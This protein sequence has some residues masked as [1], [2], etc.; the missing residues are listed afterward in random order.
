MMK[1]MSLLLCAVLFAVPAV[2]QTLSQADRD[3]GV[4]YLKQ[5]RE[6][7]VTAVKGLSDAQLNFKPAPDRWSIAEVLEHIS[8]AEGFIL[9]NVE[10]KIMKAPAGDATRDVAKTDAF[11]VAAIPD[12]SHKFQAPEPLKPTGHVPASESLSKFIAARGQ[13]IEFLQSTP[14]LR[15]HVVDSPLGKPLDAYEWLLFIGGH[16]ERH[17][18][19]ILEVKADPN[20]PKQ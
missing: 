11:V 3:H 13:T 10:Q 20:F 5:T 19:Q 9:Q 15:Q 1:T 16:S 14:D 12:R 18:K 6:G 2:A 8:L 4:D 7:V 17:T